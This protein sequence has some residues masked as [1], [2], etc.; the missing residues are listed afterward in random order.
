MLVDC[1]TDAV[2]PVDVLFLSVPER[3]TAHDDRANLEAIWPAAHIVLENARSKFSPFHESSRILV[4]TGPGSQQNSTTLV[5]PLVVAYAHTNGD[6]ESLFLGVS[7]ATTWACTFSLWRHCRK[8]VCYICQRD[9]LHVWELRLM[10]EAMC[11]PVFNSK[12][13][14][15]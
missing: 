4:M 13:F 9:P 14:P 2:R 10:V 15:Q 6:E 7:P 1:P 11:F 12:L 5:S 3:G 8:S